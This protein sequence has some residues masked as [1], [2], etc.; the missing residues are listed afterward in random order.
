MLT[1]KTFIC[2]AG[3]AIAVSALAVTEEKPLWTAGLMTDTHIGETVESCERVRL[4]YELLNDLE[5]D[6]VANCGDIAERYTERGYKILRRIFDRTFTKKKPQEVWVYANHEHVGRKNE[7]FET[8]M[9][10]VRKLLRIPHDL[11]ALIDFKGFPLVVLPQWLDP[12]R[13]EKMLGEA[14]RKYLGKPIF[15]FDHVPAMDT[16]GGSLTGGTQKR[17]D[18]F[19]RFPQTVHFSGH[20]HGSIRS[21]RQIWQGEFTAL[22]LGCL[23][24]WTGAAVGAAPARKDEFCVAVMEVFSDR[25][26]FKRIDVRDRC[27]HR[28]EERWTVPLPFNPATAPYRVDS[29]AKREAVPQFKPDAKVSLSADSA[30]ARSVTVSFPQAEATYGVY[31]YKIEVFDGESGGLVAR[32]DQ[33]GPFWM[34]P[35]ERPAQMECVLSAAYFDAGCRR[36]VSVT[37]MNCFGVCGDAIKGE[38]TLDSVAGVPVWESDEIAKD[39]VFRRYLKD[40]EIKRPKD[41]WYEMHPG[42]NRLELPKGVWDAP[43]GTR[44]RFT[45]D[46][47]SETFTPRP[48]TI[49]L[50]HPE[51]VENAN[52]RIYT[53]A[54]KTPKHRVV[55]EFAKRKADRNYYLLVREGGPGRIRFHKVKIEKLEI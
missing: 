53:A 10:D 17:R 2:G 28:S 54:G 49:V 16:T 29:A 1:R 5:V 3:S 38:L 43:A 34:R 23:A 41:G 48:W 9:Q 47:E 46:M 40:G 4:A 39:C 36:T 31:M 32:Q 15:V 35:E 20:K 24:G 11:Y 6:L 14:A 51:P 8:V 52:T 42:D 44:F 19:N 22:N 37:P 33:F 12:D 7:P 26:V 45:V 13:A 27:E 50:R 25:L 55:I 21:E 30:P 18:L